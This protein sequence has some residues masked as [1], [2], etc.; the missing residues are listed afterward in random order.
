M[1]EDKNIKYKID[2]AYK[3]LDSIQKS[4]ISSDNKVSIILG[5][6]G[7][8][9]TIIIANIRL[10]NL[11]IIVSL[12]AKTNDFCAVLYVLLLLCSALVFLVGLG[13]FYCSIR[14]R[15]NMEKNKKNGI[16]G[17][18][19]FCFTHIS[20]MTFTD[21]VKKSNEIDYTETLNSIRMLIYFYSQI[22]YEKYLSFNRGLKYLVIGS[23]CLTMLLFTGNYLYKEDIVEVSKQIEQRMDNVPSFVKINNCDIY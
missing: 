5:I 4:I 22:C 19:I 14:A 7:V 1:C 12:L 8:L 11:R 2:V 13:F 17:S 21:Y 23:C 10:I 16:N 15:I 3:T 9:L 20:K 6:F 18:S